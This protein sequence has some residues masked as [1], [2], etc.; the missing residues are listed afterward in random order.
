MGEAK[1]RERMFER[2]TDHVLRYR[3][4]DSTTIWRVFTE[5]GGWTTF[6]LPTVDYLEDLVKSAKKLEQALSERIPKA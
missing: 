1:R 6:A 5:D 4:S 2:V 3:L